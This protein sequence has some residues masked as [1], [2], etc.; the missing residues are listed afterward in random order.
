MSRCFRYANATGNTKA[1]RWPKTAN[2]NY[3]PLLRRGNL[4][5]VAIYGS[6]TLFLFQRSCA[7]I[8]R[9]YSQS[10]TKMRV[11]LVPQ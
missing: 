6:L 8:W 9:Q 5:I 11:D 3:D 10:I 4:L 1:S 2:R 7:D